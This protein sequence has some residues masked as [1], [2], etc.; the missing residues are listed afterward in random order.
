MAAPSFSADYLS[1]RS[2]KSKFVRNG[3]LSM[4]LM[5]GKRQRNSPRRTFKIFADIKDGMSTETKAD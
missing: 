5:Q 3:P 4:R 1:G 2:S